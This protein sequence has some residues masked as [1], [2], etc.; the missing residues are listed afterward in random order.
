[1]TFVKSMALPLSVSRQTGT[2]IHQETF[3]A[4]KVDMDMK[5]PRTS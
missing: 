2:I 1:M 4:R 5:G 3:I